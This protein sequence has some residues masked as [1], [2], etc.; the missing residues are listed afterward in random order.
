MNPLRVGMDVSSLAL[1]RAGTAR[2][3]ESL[4]EA[5]EHEPDLELRKYGLGGGSSR[6]LVPVR[7]LGWYLAALPAKAKRD[8][9]D[10]LHCPTHRAPVRSPVPLVVTFHDLAVLRHPGDVQ[11][12]DAHLQ[13]ARAPASGEGGAAPDR[14]LRVHQARADRPARRARGE[15][16]RDPER[17]RPAVRG[18]RARRRPATTS[19]RSPRSSRARTCRA[20]SRPTGGLT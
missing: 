9:V 1:T 15:G 3:I 12:L 18:R 7:D 14:G 6:A 19:W 2:H 5:L 8:G 13:P 17:G 10:V 16:A 11:P 4:L 20:S